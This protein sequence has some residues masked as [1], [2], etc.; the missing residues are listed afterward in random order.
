M[1]TAPNRSDKGRPDL[2]ETITGLQAYAL[3]GADCLCAPGLKT[4]EQIAAVVKAVAPKPV[5]LLIGSATS[6]LTVHDGAAQQGHGP[7]SSTLREPQA[8]AL[9]ISSKRVVYRGERRSCRDAWALRGARWLAL[10][11]PTESRPNRSLSASMV[12]IRS[13]RPSG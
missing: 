2:E 10:A 8:F 7:R 1:P 11:T 13:R 9:R 6:G 4:R 3:A 5:N 12:C